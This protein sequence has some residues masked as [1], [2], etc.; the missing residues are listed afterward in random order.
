MPILVGGS[1]L[2]IDS[3]IFDYNFLPAGPTGQREALNKLSTRELLKKVEQSG[4]DTSGIDVRNKRRLIRLLESGGQRPLRGGLRPH[5]LVLGLHVP[6]DKLEERITKRVDD[7]LVGGLEQEV[8]ELAELYGW[9]VEPM[10][11]IGYKEFQSYFEGKQTLEQTRERIKRSTTQLAKKQRTWF[12]RNNS[13]QWLEDPG[14][15]HT[16]VQ[17]FLS[18]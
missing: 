10:K 18:K 5:T 16:I 15:A 14:Q 12:K 6:P 3:V 2:Y 17:N 7:M 4:L 11:G 13:I 8:R 9:D 1:G